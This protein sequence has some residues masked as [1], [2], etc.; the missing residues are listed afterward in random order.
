[1]RLIRLEKEKRLGYGIEGVLKLKSHQFFAGVDF[2]KLWECNE[3]IKECIYSQAQ[4]A[5]KAQ[6]DLVNYAYVCPQNCYAYYEDYFADAKSPSVIKD[7]LLRINNGWVFYQKRRLV[8]TDEPHLSYYILPMKFQGD[9]KLG[10]SV[11]AI[12]KNNERFDIL[13]DKGTVKLK[14]S[15]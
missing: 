10:K 7:G 4:L 14:V 15:L 1:M 11:L 12:L 3:E 9:I 13:T 2:T 5:D 8:L 6:Q